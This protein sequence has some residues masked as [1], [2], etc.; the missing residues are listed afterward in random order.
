MDPIGLVVFPISVCILWSPSGKVPVIIDMFSCIEHLGLNRPS[1]DLSHMVT[2]MRNPLEIIRLV[3]VIYSL[4]VQ[5]KT[6]RLI[7]VMDSRSY[8]GAKS[9]QLGL[10]ASAVNNHG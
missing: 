10:C 2:N 3:G 8:Q 5:N 6:K 4:E 1:T 9:G 7:H